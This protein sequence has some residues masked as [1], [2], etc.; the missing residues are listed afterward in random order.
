MLRVIM[1]GVIVLLAVGLTLVGYNVFILGTGL[2]G[3]LGLLHS[4]WRDAT[5]DPSTTQNIQWMIIIAVGSLF[6]WRASY[7]RTSGRY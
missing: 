5:S 6:A 7:M 2:A 1:A 3:A 4:Y